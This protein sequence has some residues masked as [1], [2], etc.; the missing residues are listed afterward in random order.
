MGLIGEQIVTNPTTV[1]TIQ[2]AAFLPFTHDRTPKMP[3]ALDTIKMQPISIQKILHI[4]EQKNKAAR[5][6]SCVRAWTLL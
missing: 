4:H 5:N 3:N 6:S 2:I 1:I